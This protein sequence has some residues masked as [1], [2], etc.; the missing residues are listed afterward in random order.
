MGM[1]AVVIDDASSDGT[2]DWLAGQSDEQL[3]A[4]VFE[5]QTDGLLSAT[6]KSN[7]LSEGGLVTPPTS[8]HKGRVA[9][10]PRRVDDSAGSRSLEGIQRIVDGYAPDP[11]RRGWSVSPCGGEFE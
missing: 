4:I 2:E 10:S 1:S 11:G 7:T 8:P 9:R 6:E 5:E 3:T